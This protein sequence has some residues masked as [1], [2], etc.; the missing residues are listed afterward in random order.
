MNML[1][2]FAFVFNSILVAAAILM[3]YEVLSI[4]D[5]KLSG[6]GRIT[7][8]FRVL[9]GVGVIFMTHVTEIWLFAMG[10]FTTMQLEGTGTLVAHTASHGLFM[11]CVYLSFVTFTTVGY[12]DFVAEGYVRYL[13]GVEALTGLILITWSASFLFIEMQKYW[14]D[15]KRVE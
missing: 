15:A 5:R 4:L 9:L 2:L 13:T 3:H 14:T 12:G 8:R 1:L 7:P 11:D 10:Y 6:F